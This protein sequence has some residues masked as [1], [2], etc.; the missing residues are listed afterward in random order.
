MVYKIKF[1]EQ[2]AIKDT[3]KIPKEEIKSIRDDIYKLLTFDPYAYSKPLKGKFKGLRRL[4]VGAY[5]V[6][7]TIFEKEVLISRILC[8]QETYK[9]LARSL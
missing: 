6:V 8:R 1:T 3:K 2:A 5:R 9:V 4:R 7:F